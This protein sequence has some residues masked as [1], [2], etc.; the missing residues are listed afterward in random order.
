M[1]IIEPSSAADFHS[2]Y[3]LRWRILRAPWDQP[4]GSERDAQDAHST[5]LML[6]D[7]AGKALAVGRLHF[8][9]IREAQIRYMA[10]EVDRR[11]SG[12]GTHLLATL[13]H[14]AHTLGAAR[15][16]LD[17]RETALGFYRKHGY[18]IDGSGHM[19]F[20]RIAHV[21]MSKRLGGE[22]PQGR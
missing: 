3:D 10:V 13:E 11:R 15:I 16:V 2:Y 12:L 21:R 8:N 7:S 6:I 22:P 4:R 18:A 17:A 20:N 5:H 1:R 14:R 9:S 19:L